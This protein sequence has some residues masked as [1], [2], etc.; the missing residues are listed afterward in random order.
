MGN[1]LSSDEIK[2]E[3]F[4]QN[5]I[6]DDWHKDNTT[7][8]N[9]KKHTHAALSVKHGIGSNMLWGCSLAGIG[10]LAKVEGITKTSKYQSMLVLGFC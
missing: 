5:S 7:Y 2:V 1:V 9:N 3:G 10:A 6:K 4:G 8:H